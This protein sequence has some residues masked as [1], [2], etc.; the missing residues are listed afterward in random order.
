MPT[1]FNTPTL[2]GGVPGSVGGAGGAF[3]KP[4]SS[5]RRR[6]ACLEGVDCVVVSP[7]AA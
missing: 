7:V 1:R 6:D 2:A 3:F 5:P 4:A